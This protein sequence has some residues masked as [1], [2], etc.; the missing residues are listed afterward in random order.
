MEKKTK[1]TLKEN[2]NKHNKNQ[3]KK[4]KL[5][6]ITENISLEK[7]KWNDTIKQGKKKEFKKGKITPEEEEKITNALCEYAF[8][9]DLSKEELLNIIIEKQTKD[10]KIW[11]RIAECLP[12]RSVQSIHNFCHRKFNPFNYKGEWTLLKEKALINLVKEHGKK[13]ELIA[14]K[15]ERT[16]LNCKDKYKSL[17]KENNNLNE[18]SIK[19]NKKFKKFR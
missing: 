9:N 10:K 11:P 16:A 5:E 7:R 4:K 1:S 13:W 18:N 12:N 6:K 17:G 2:K 8:E 14:Q 3:S 15:L 19:K